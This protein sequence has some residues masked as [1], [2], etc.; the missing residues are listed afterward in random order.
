MLFTEIAIVYS[1]NDKILENCV[2]R[3]QSLN[4]KAGGTYS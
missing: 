4:V 1:K 2:G 3:V